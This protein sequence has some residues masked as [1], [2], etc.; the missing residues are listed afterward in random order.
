MTHAGSGQR[1]G[2]DRHGR[3]GR[4][5]GKLAV[6]LP[7]LGAV[8]TTFI[9]GVELVRRRRAQ[10][11]GSLTQLGMIELEPGAS[12]AAS[13]VPIRDL[14]PL[15]PVESLTFGA[16]D[17]V[18]E[19]GAT[20]AERSGVLSSEHLSEVHET[21]RGV[22]PRPG[23]Y[24]PGSVRK[25]RANHVKWVSSHR[26]KIEALRDDIRSFVRELG[27][28]RAVMVFCASTETYR[29]QDSRATSSLAAFEDA[30]ERSDP[31]ISPT[32]LYA[33][34]AL[35]EKVPFANG[36][37]NAAVDTVALQELASREGVPVCGK[38]FKSGQ[39]M[40]KTALAPALRA[41]MLGLEG[42]FSGNILGNR[43]GEVLEDPEAFKAKE[44][45]KSGV[46]DSIL[47]PERFPGL[48][49]HV[50]H[51]VAIHYY[52]PRGDA[53]EG[54]DNVDLFGWLDYPMQL[55][56]NFLC[57]DSILAAPLVLDLALLLDLAHRTGWG[58]MQEWLGFYFK[59][60]MT[61]PGERALH[62]LFRQEAALH[63]ALRELGGHGAD[64]GQGAPSH[65]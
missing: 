3:P 17:I 47:D 40:V 21:L 27:A 43:D 56:L 22:M 38:D 36:T 33:Y 19:D 42:W 32:M 44:V 11:T 54:W 35:M 13:L 46:L 55:K 23:V 34:A 61:R 8:A 39:T 10:P 62:D 63:R 57:R 30:L 15:A 53:K 29:H 1:P 25:I 5:D 18:A 49:G 16:W 28:S 50:S 26:E 65:A 51:K 41:R 20:V 48:Y 52:P 59:S 45:T 60:P 6:L 2:G 64:G 9:A 7:G 58:G 31:A 14:L 37:P 12:A 4:P 24:D